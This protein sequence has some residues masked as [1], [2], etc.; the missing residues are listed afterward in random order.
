M[1]ELDNSVDYA[2]NVIEE[3]EYKQRMRVIF[4]K[5]AKMVAH[6]VGPYGSSTLI[7][8][9]GDYHST[10]DGFTVIKNARFNGRTNNTILNLIKRISLQMVVKVGDG[11]TTAILAA[12]EFLEELTKSKIL[13]DF[14]PKDI[15]KIINQYVDL[16][17]AH[18]QNN[19]TQISDEDFLKVMTDIARVATN[20][21]E[22]LTG[23]IHDIYEESGRD[24]VISKRMSPTDKASYKILD[25]M[26]YIEGRY[27]DKIYCNSANGG[28]CVIDNPL[29]LTFNFT[30]GDEHWGIIQAA[31]KLLMTKYPSRRLVIIAPNYDQY[32][33]DH[34]K[35]DVQDFTT[36][37]T[38]GGGGGAIPFPL[39]FARNPFFK[40]SERA[41]Y[42]DL[43]PFIGS[44]MITPLV[45]DTLRKSFLGYMETASTFNNNLKHLQELQAAGKPLP[46]REQ[47]PTDDGSTILQKIM[48]D[49]ESY[50]GKCGKISIG[51][52]HIEFFDFT[53]K[54]QNLIDIHVMDAKD[55]YNKELD[56]IEN[57]RLIS[58]TFIEARERLARIAC[59]SAMIYVGGNSELEKKMNDDAL[60][61][62]IRACQSAS[63]YGYN[64]GNN[65]AIFKALK[66]VDMSSLN[67]SE[68]DQK[69]VRGCF[70][71]AFINVIHTI[72]AN[73]YGEH[74]VENTEAIIETS[75]EKGKCF[76]LN[77]ETYDSNIINS[78]R[79]DIEILMGAITIVAQILISNQYL[80]VDVQ[81]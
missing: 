48:D 63:T 14:R 57:M 58:K 49:I 39:V 17:N 37:Y 73:K 29:I 24:T 32:F 20:D 68:T 70:E 21:N 8:E 6:T 38:Q 25:N 76:D 66:E 28:K 80:A 69:R 67:L 40:N 78:C 35:Q 11:S 50:F 56:Q 79:T 31:Q 46:P 22:E 34:V 2:W 27:I 4:D 1:V 42:D 53:N 62:A 44:F 41:I 36:A 71:N 45:A 16:L 81:R 75:L 13:D 52:D 10:K 77:T 18:I 9:M 61:D 65:L 19:A 7:E 51:D 3:E 72:H 12:H 43:C 26:F 64:L 33:L 5:I 15:T 30:M 60:D 47:M 54:N 23:F 74:P 55:Q 59:K